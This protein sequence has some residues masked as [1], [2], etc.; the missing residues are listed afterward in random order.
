[1]ILGIKDDKSF[2]S[3]KPLFHMVMDHAP[4]DGGADDRISVELQPLE[5]MYHKPSIDQVF[6]SRFSLFGFMGMT[7]SQT[8][9]A[10]A[11]FKL[12]EFIMPQIDEYS[13]AKL[14]QLAGEKIQQLEKATRAT[15]E[16]ELEQHKVFILLLF[17][18]C[19]LSLLLIKSNLINSSLVSRFDHELESSHYHSPRERKGSGPL[20][21]G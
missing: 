17:F 11:F 4:P 13:M 6:T 5:I 2:N 12:V 20:H 21:C 16:H 7:F 14:V 9:P 15:L 19:W 18:L 10:A 1:M 3:R 8:F